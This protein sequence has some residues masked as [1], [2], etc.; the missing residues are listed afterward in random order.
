MKSPVIGYFKQRNYEVSEE[1]TLFHR[2]IDI[3][4]RNSHSIVS[5][6][7]KL[8]DWKTAIHQAYLNQRV[9][10]YSYVGLPDELLGD[11]SPDFFVQAASYG[12]GI[13]A[14]DGVARRVMR[15]KASRVIQPF[16][17]K[18]FLARLR[19]GEKN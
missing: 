9:S 7:L 13:L 3:V 5:V 6:E 19:P 16:L 17:R 12:V 4:A 10:N 8:K 2:K 11:L 18:E 15:P 1:V 14:V